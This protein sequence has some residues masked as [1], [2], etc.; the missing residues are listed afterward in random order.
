[1]YN[2][3]S[4]ITPQHKAST[5]KAGTTRAVT[6]LLTRGEGSLAETGAFPSGCWWAVQHR[7]AV[8]IS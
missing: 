4:P 5:S 3:T 2:R 8:A 6:G 1:M 7:T